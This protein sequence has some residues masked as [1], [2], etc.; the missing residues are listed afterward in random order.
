MLKRVVIIV[1]LLGAAV[2]AGAKLGV[3]DMFTVKNPGG[4]RIGATLAEVNKTLG[5]PTAE[6][7]NFGR[8]QRF[9][10]AQSG[11]AYM[12]TFEDDKV[13]EIH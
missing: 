6:L 1:L 5:P 7:P 10:K 11:R 13:V 4:V 9:Y 12:I 2:W 3:G 8:T